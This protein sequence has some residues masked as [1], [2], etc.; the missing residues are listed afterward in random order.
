VINKIIFII[1]FFSFS[2][3]Y[4]SEEI[5]FYVH[6]GAMISYKNDK[7]IVTPDLKVKLTT[8]SPTFAEYPNLIGEFQSTLTQKE[9]SELKA[10]IQSQLKLIQDPKTQPLSGA[11]VEELHIGNVKKFWTARD[12]SD[13]VIGIRK[14]FLEIAHKAYKN[15][16]KALGLE[17]SQNSKEVKCALKNSS[18][19]AI[20]TVDPQ[21]VNYSLFCLDIS[22]NRSNLHEIKEYDP[23]K[24]A[25]EKIEIKPADQFNF[26][27]KTTE[28]C[29]YRIIMKTSQMM[30]NKN[31]QDTLLGEIV[32][33]QLSE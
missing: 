30:I 8:L 32:S 9:Y 5:V 28:V 2:S 29:D 24:M 13:S 25:P 6:G 1:I 4:A 10:Y 20:T 21:G 22:G 31:Y 19:E 18:V 26:S 17:C 11:L 33:N 15:P 16:V 12:Q 27:I 23:R 7:I 14:K 3:T